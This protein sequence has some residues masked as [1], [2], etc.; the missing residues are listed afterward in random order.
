MPSPT[1]FAFSA[2]KN[3]YILTR[4]LGKC[5]LKSN[6]ILD[7]AASRRQPVLGDTWAGSAHTTL[8][9]RDR[10][11]CTHLE[12]LVF[13]HDEAEVTLVTSNLFSY[14]W[15]RLW[16]P[17]AFSSISM[18]ASEPPFLVRSTFRSWSHLW[19]QVSESRQ[20]YQTQH[21]SLCGVL[22]PY[23]IQRI[24]SV[25]LTDRS[26]SSSTVAYSGQR[27]CEFER[28]YDPVRHW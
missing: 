17:P 25:H 18:I 11:N 6:F 7:R 20:N 5:V 12:G 14:E 22:L 10:P 21:P 28:L 15:S 9:L 1:L 24:L 19:H 8:R 4:W 16:D 3:L 2:K 23:S 26:L 13:Q 27:C